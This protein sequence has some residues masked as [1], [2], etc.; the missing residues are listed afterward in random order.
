V[1]LV[2]AT[3]SGYVGLRYGRLAATHRAFQQGIEKG[4]AYTKTSL[5]P[6]GDNPLLVFQST[7]LS[8]TDLAPNLDQALVGHL[9]DTPLQVVGT[10]PVPGRYEGSDIAGIRVDRER[11]TFPRHGEYYLRTTIGNLKLLLLDPKEPADGHALAV[12][13]FVSRNCV[14]SLADERLIVPNKFY[15]DYHRP[16]KAL[17]KLFLSDQPLALHCGYVVDVLNYVLRKAGFDVQRVQLLAE[18]GSQGHLVGQVYLPAAKKWA[19]IDPDYGA[20]VRDRA[21]RWLSVQE[22][23]EAARRGN[24]SEVFVVDIGNK[25]WLKDDYNLPSHFMSP[26]TWRVDTMTDH[27]TIQED[28]YRGMMRQYTH[29]IWLY[30]YDE[31]FQWRRVLQE[32]GT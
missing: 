12:A 30:E 2:A 14:H 3:V 19:M 26:F 31:V 11:L 23:A 8:W 32:A 22:I 6:L 13:R 28:Q 15:Y 21:G 20:I 5:D 7:T 17:P 18:G 4:I 29:E 16:D 9:K 10:F 24:V 25:R 27:R 1:I